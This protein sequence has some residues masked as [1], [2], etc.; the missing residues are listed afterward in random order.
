[1]TVNRQ[2]HHTSV[3]RQYHH[4]SSSAAYTAHT[5]HVT[6]AL[7]I[8]VVRS[9]NRIEPRDARAMKTR[10][11]RLD[12][13]SRES[14]SVSD[15]RFNH[16]SPISVHRRSQFAVWLRSG[17]GESQSGNETSISIQSAGGDRRVAVGERNLNLHSI[18]RRRLSSQVGG[19]RIQIVWPHRVAVGRDPSSTCLCRLALRTPHSSVASSPPRDTPGHVCSHHVCSH[20]VVLTRARWPGSSHLGVGRFRPSAPSARW[21]ER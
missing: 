12:A 8:C 15:R 4:T 3:N 16:Q 5:S 14:V 19:D 17:T 6:T 2:Y 11:A 20:H 13:Q 9:R 21:A 7:R 1:L 10:V 18:C